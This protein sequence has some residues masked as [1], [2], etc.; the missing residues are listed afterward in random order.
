MSKDNFN[1]QASRAL[2]SLK[3]DPLDHLVALTMAQRAGQAGP[4]A[5]RL[6]HMQLATDPMGPQSDALDEYDPNEPEMDSDA[7]D[8][9]RMHSM[10][11]A[12]ASEAEINRMR[13]RL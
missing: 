2:R 9:R 10:S 3:K 11:G 13:G 8:M 5:S 4:D 6:N 12:A 1:P 7:D